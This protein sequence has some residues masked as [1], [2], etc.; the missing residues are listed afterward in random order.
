VKS[1]GYYRLGAPY[2]PINTLNLFGGT[3]EP[4]VIDGITGQTG[5]G[6]GERTGGEDVLNGRIKAQWNA[7]DDLTLLLQYEMLRDRSDAVPAFNDTPPDGP[8]L[9]N[10]F[11]FTR[12]TGDPLDNMGS[13]QRND[14]LLRMDDGQRI[15]VDG[16]YLNAEWALNRDYT[17]FMAAGRRSQEEHLPNT[18][19]GAAPVNTVT[20]QVLSLFDATR[21]TKRTTTQ[22]ELR[23]ASSFEGPFNYVVGGFYQE[24]DARFCVVQVLGFIDLALPF[25]ALGLPAQFSNNNPS[26]LCNAQDSDSLAGFVDGTYEFSDRLRLSAG[27]RYT[28]DE[29]SWRGRTQVPFGALDPANPGLTA[30]DLRKPLD[31]ADFGRFPGGTIVDSSTPGFDNLSR[32]WNESSWRVTGSFDLSEQ[33]FS[34][35]TVSRGYKAGGYNDQTGTSGLLVPTL[36]RP[37]DPEFVTNYEFGLKYEAPSGRWRLNSSVFLTEYEDAQRAV[38]ILT[39]QGGAQFQET[40]FYNAAEVE[41]RGIEVEFQALL[42]DA[43]LLR[44]QASYLKAEYDSFIIDQP[45]LTDPV[46]GGSILPFSSDFS[47]LPVPRS[48]EWSGSIAGA[49]T[50]GMRGG[51]VEF[52]A[53]VYYE[54]ENLYYIAAPGRE[55]DAYLNAKTL[56]NASITFTP[57]SDQYFVRA[58]GKNLTDKRYRIASQSVATLWTHT[59][60]G[61]PRSYGIE[62]GFRF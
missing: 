8:Y 47:G 1:D 4:F 28:R 10:F 42:T 53:E 23:L 18:Y 11:G 55:F 15:D 36:T 13:T 35:L 41:A 27:Y 39:E 61:A 29:K 48:P 17:V 51:D 30:A 20:G 12:P 59:Q 45:A 25:E 16:V 40:V 9:W 54:A 57:N 2:G 34:Y 44:A 60:W 38:N 52:S 62:A 7:T 46:T 3:F 31:A 49:Y 43:F 37:V 26:I 56:I 32:T 50:L 21:D 22:L 14:F 19:T 58:F 24:N 33:I 5:S 6:T